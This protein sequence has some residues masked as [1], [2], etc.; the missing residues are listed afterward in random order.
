MTAR[1][2]RCLAIDTA[3]DKPNVAICHGDRVVSRAMDDG[4]R[5]EQIFRHVD[6]A[7]AEAEL[8][9]EA[10]DCIAVGRGPGSFT[11][12]R[13]GMAAAQGLAYGAGL[14]ICS[15]SSLAVMALGAGRRAGAA[16][17]VAALDARMGE[18]Y[19]GSYRIGAAGAEVIDADRVLAP[20]DLTVAGEQPFVAA[21]PGW[22]VHPE[23]AARLADRI[24]SLDSACRP[25]AADLLELARIAFDQ[26]E[27]VVPAAA[28]PVYLRD[29]VTG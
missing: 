19:A 3:S 22:A 17:V 20:A 21:G 24:L 23:L 7:L 9:L 29:Q 25:Q 4:G 1:E 8:V 2:F 14:R 16:Y 18:V 27:A 10:L 13:V 26:G 6:A 5:T 28:L 15:I 11:G 12:L